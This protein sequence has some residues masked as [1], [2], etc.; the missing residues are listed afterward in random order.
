ME[1]QNEQKEARRAAEAERDAKYKL[2][3]REIGERNRINDI[4]RR[5]DNDPETKGQ[6]R[7]W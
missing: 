2:L 3:R 6:W 1:E 5:R 4:I 7:R